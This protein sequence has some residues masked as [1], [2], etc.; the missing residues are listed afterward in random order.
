[1]KRKDF[2]LFFLLPFA[3]IF[4]IF[5]FISSI[6]RT[7]IQRAGE[8][9]ILE[10]LQ[11]T[12]EILK[13]NIGHFLEEG[14]APEA[15]FKPF[16][17]E[18]N[19]YYLALLDR[20]NRILSWSSRYEGYLP[21]SARDSGRKEPWIITSPAGK[22]F[23]LLTPVTGENEEPY[24]LYLGYSLGSLEQMAASSRRNFLFVF[25]FLAAVGVLFFIG[26]FGLQRNY[27]EK[28][29]EAEEEKREKEK[30]KEISGLTSAV[31]H[32]IK[33]P[34]N[35]LALLCELL[36]KKGPPEIK[37]N[38]ALG[39][40]EVR[41]ISQVIDQFSDA[42]KPL[43]LNKERTCLRDI[44]ESARLSLPAE[45]GKS[46]VFFRYKE[47]KPI[48]LEA[49]K[50]LLARAFLNLLRNAFEATESGSVSVI[51]EMRR[52]KVRV[53]VEDT[54]K[55]IAREYL[56]RLFDPFFTTKER[57][58]GIGLYLARKI[59]EAHEGKIEVKSELGRGTAFVIQLPGG[60]H[61]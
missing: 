45:S 41:K 38:A 52:K 29:K 19:I 11:A 22:I 56:G 36:Y 26:I 5:F 23:N 25:G 54:G 58:M 48:V 39:K 8:G 49:D 1:M 47:D 3:G 33:N 18:E 4:I 20:D 14:V 24:V 21:F 60:S 13:V 51:A 50:G 2:F 35:S 10:Q 37:E 57:G 46:A 7:F 34:L 15:I 28:K 32:E 27:L 30:F 12:A 55:G 17:A 9:L 53:R 43:R 40:E 6:N 44:V 31:A 42:L 61:E 16:A 59:V